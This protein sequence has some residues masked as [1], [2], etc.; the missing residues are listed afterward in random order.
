MSFASVSAGL[1]DRIALL[2]SSTSANAFAQKCE[3]SEGSIRQYLN[4][5]IPRMDKVVTMARVAGV[6]L[7]WLATGEGPMRAEKRL[8]GDLDERL[9]GEVIHA[10]TMALCCEAS[11]ETAVG[12]ARLSTEIYAILAGM[13]LQSDAERQAAIE[14]ALARERR[15]AS[16]QSPC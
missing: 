1:A 9:L 14:Y 15:K 16:A 10:V 2:I 3:I 12:V 8:G 13:D 5:S 11:P 6:R 4:G 7:E